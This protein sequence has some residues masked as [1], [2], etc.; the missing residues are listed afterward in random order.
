M[1]T[2]N[3]NKS[4]LIVS[5]EWKLEKIEKDVD[6]TVIA[7]NVIL[8]RGEKVF[9]VAFKNSGDG[10]S[11]LFFLAIKL[12]KIGLQVADVVCG[13]EGFDTHFTMKEYMPEKNILK[14]NCEE[15]N[16]QL[17]TSNVDA[18]SG[19]KC[20][21]VFQIHLEVIAS[22][23]SYNPCDRL[24]KEQ[25]WATVNSKLHADV[26]FIVKD[27]LFSAHKAIIAARS[28]VFRVEFVEEEPK[29]AN[30]HQI[31]IKSF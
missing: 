7:S 30:P 25:L 21:F 1:A 3:L 2:A 15:G 12:N 27:K 6:K 5:Y 22:G 9:R 20:S 31:R 23:Y 29:N 8:F 16:L 18:G 19:E 11:T 17:F 24:G 28:R 4:L 13:K 10:Q 14:S 26:E